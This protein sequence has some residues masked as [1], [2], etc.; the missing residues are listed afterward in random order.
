MPMYKSFS[1][2]ALHQFCE[3]LD[4]RGIVYR[5]KGIRVDTLDTECYQLASDYGLKQENRHA[6]NSERKRW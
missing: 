2:T 5:V 4:N 1:D 6:D 3:A